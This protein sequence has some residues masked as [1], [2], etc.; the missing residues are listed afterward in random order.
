MT[1]H[2]VTYDIRVTHATKGLPAKLTGHPD[3]WAPEEPSE[4]SCIAKDEN[5]NVV[6]L[7]DE[8]LAEAERQYIEY[9]NDHD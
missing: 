8:Q 5:G 7:T 2:G 6:E 4:F 3:T 9:C 1:I